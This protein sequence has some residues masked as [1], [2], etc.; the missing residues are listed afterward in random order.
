MSAMNPVRELDPDARPRDWIDGAFSANDGSEHLN[1]CPEPAQP[2]PARV[3]AVATPAQHAPARAEPQ[4]YKV[5]FEASEEYVELVERAKALLSHTT[6][7]ADLS[8]LHLRAMRALV[9]E[10][11]RQKNTR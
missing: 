11:E 9:T 1:D 8:E 6:P 3:N 10:L 5:Q 4:R 7:R 2:A